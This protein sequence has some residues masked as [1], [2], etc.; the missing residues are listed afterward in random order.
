MKLVLQ[1]FGLLCIYVTIPTKATASSVNA[2]FYTVF[3]T[4]R[5]PIT[6]V[7]TSSY[8]PIAF[9]LTDRQFQSTLS[10]P[11]GGPDPHTAGDVQAIWPGLEPANSDSVLQNVVANQGRNA[12]QWLFLPFYCCE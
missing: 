6:L 1:I 3:F 11:S 4:P 5:A 12:G 10:I 9:S 7:S 2:I 8:S